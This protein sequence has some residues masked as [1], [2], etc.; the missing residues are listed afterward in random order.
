MYFSKGIYMKKVFFDDM[1]SFDFFKKSCLL[2]KKAYD[3]GI[4]F[5]KKKGSPVVY[6]TNVK[7]FIPQHDKVIFRT[8]LNSRGALRDFIGIDW[9]LEKGDSDKLKQAILGCKKFSE[10]YNASYIIYPTSSFPKKPRMRSVFFIDKLLNSEEY[11][12][13]VTFILKE[14][15]I[16]PND[17][18]NFDV[19]HQFNLPV[20]TNEY[21][22]K[23]VK[24]V[25]KELLSF[26]LFK[27]VSIDKKYK[28]NKTRKIKKYPCLGITFDLEKEAR[29]DSN[30]DKAIQHILSEMDKGEN[31]LYNFDD[32]NTIV[33]KF[34]HSL[35]RAETIGSI[36][37]EQA[38]RILIAI[39]Q[40]NQH[41]EQQ[42]V[43]DYNVEY[44]R[45]SSDERQLE[46]A[47]PFQR[48]AGLD[49]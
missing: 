3:N 28:R 25:Q 9:D 15:G 41:Y 1:N 8:E 32:Y 34:M 20:F 14:I 16:D 6:S 35:A 12:K 24:I 43:L 37:R 49:W 4:S 42:N 31:K 47:V 11:A 17:D 40:G 2:A 45:V 26:E 18:N 5:S 46:Y 30:V 7:N 29:D 44:N 39:A 23:L 22:L 33:V 38:E 19:K 27:D 10:K 48:Y 21:Q 13:G 36:T